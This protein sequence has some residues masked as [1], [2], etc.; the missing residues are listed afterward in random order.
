MRNEED[1]NFLEKK[2][3]KKFDKKKNTNLIANLYISIAL[4]NFAQ[5]M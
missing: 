5:I 1:Q 4:I 2:K 3:K